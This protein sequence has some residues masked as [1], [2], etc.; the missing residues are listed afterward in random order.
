MQAANH[1]R[2][3]TAGW[4]YKDW[5]GLFY[6]PE[7]QRR[8][9]HALE[10]LAHFFDVVEINTSFYG[11]IKPELG[12]L[13]VRRAA[14]GNPRF[15]FTAKLHKSFTHSPLAAMEPSAAS[16]PCLRERTQSCVRFPSAR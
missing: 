15:C 2:I 13:W 16:H 12:K 5:E 1:I 9:V 6:P 3:G 7:V 10:Y 8:K 4:S 11:P 14:A